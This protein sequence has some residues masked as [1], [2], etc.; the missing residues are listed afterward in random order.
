M[1]NTEKNVS[2]TRTDRETGEI[3]TITPEMEQRLQALEF[4]IVS[5]WVQ[6][7]INIKTIRDERL[8]LVRCETFSEYV[9]GYL[10]E[11]LG[12]STSNIWKHLKIA[13]TYSDT[14]LKKA[15]KGAPMQSLIELSRNPELVKDLND[16]T[17]EIEGDK[18]VYDDGTFES[19]AQ[20]RE[21]IKKETAEAYKKK[22]EEKDLHAKGRETILK[23]YQKRVQEQ[24]HEIEKMKKAMAR[25]IDQK[26]IDPKH[27]MRITQKKEAINLINEVQ[28]RIV[29]ALGELSYIPDNLLDPDV[30]SQI[31]STVAMLSAGAVRLR[32]H[33]GAIAWLP[34]VE[35]DPANIDVVPE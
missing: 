27:V 19:L 30:T 15:A 4:S 34:K 23:D 22:L 8:Y 13:T 5:N 2:V 20:V 21:R 3:I 28:R 24:Q 25:L 29:E 10:R 11:S 7:A 26:G 9:Q 33:Y 18:V 12:I 31:A 17:A 35:D 32:E 6:T 16:G 1:K 14:V